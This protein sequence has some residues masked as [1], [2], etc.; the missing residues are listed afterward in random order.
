MSQSETIRLSVVIPAFN[1]ERRLPRTLEE[2]TRYLGRQSYS[3]E[4]VVADDGSTDAT[5]RIVQERDRNVVPVRLV[6]HPDGRNHGKGAAVRLGMLA[7]L[8]RFR[9]FTDADNSTT[10]DH[11]ERFW[12]FFDEG[13]DVVIGSRG[14]KESVLSVSQPWYRRIAGEGGNLIIRALAVP[15]V[16]DTQAGFKMLT[17]ACAESL[18]PRLTIDRWGFDVEMLAVARHL[19]YRI[20]EV[21]ITWRNDPEG[22]VT[23]MTYFEVL[24]E[25][26]HVRGNLKAGVYDSPV[27][28]AN[29]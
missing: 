19:G 29:R 9:L 5:A 7:A 22:K 20:R 4:V 12:P 1:E 27:K 17:A 23:L 14:M 18:F 2:I 10:I 8:G 26:W 3:A 21:P 13:V 16:A 28:S 15:G 6:T 24:G 25:V 11:V